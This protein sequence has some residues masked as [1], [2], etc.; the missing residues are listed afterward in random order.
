MWVKWIWICCTR[1]FTRKTTTRLDD[2]EK[3]E[4]KYLHARWVIATSSGRNA[5]R[6]MHCLGKEKSFRET[7]VVHAISALWITKFYVETFMEPFENCVACIS[8]HQWWHL[9]SDVDIIYKVLKELN[10]TKWLK[11]E[12]TLWIIKKLLKF[13]KRTLS[14]TVLTL[15]PLK[16]S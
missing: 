14:L 8:W 13:L 11:R 12:N 15:F 16:S 6:K 4:W 1:C 3:V 10:L 2:V 9:R 7:A 5:I